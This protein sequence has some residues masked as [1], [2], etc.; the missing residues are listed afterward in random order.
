MKNN[1][2]Y[3]E[4]WQKYQYALDDI[5]ALQCYLKESHQE[6]DTWQE[7]ADYLER[8]LIEAGLL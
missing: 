6:T 8:L 3:E 4:L 1:L 5:S 2:S 7:Y